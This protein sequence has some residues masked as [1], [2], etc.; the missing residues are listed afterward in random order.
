MVLRWFDRYTELYGLH[1]VLRVFD[2]ARPGDGVSACFRTS[3]STSGDLA[4]AQP[5]LKTLVA[6][7]SVLGADVGDLLPHS[8]P[9]ALKAEPSP[10][11][12]RETVSTR[13]RQPQL[14]ADRL[15]PAML[16]IERVE[17]VHRERVQDLV[18]DIT[19]G[20]IFDLVLHLPGVAEQSGAVLLTHGRANH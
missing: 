17:R 5:E 7:T 2:D 11:G 1:P 18:R 3:L 10:D 4:S 14:V 19:R 8:S 20:V 12:F 13:R 16:G 6:I 9:D 15:H